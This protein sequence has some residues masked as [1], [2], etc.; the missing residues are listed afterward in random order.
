MCQRTIETTMDDEEA[1][2]EALAEFAEHFAPAPPEDIAMVCDD[3][4]ELMDPTKHP[5]ELAKANLEQML[6]NSR[7]GRTT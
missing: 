3:C 5:A 1:T 4:Y 6:K 2:K 7:E